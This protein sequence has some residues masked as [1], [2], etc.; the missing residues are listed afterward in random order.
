MNDL[1]QSVQVVYE[2]EMRRAKEALPLWPFLLSVVVVLAFVI[3]KISCFIDNDFVDFCFIELS[4]WE[5]VG[6]CLIAALF[7]VSFTAITLHL[8]H[9]ELIDRIKN[10]S[11]P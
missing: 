3:Q 8:K 1:E 4:W 7:S 5:V 2:R 6:V 9:R 11:L 10:N